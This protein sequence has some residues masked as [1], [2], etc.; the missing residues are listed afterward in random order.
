MKPLFQIGL[1]LAGLAQSAGVARGQAGPD[2]PAPAYQIQPA[3][4]LDQLLGPIA[5]YPDPLIA[6]LLPA[7]TLPAQIVLADRY[8][9]AGGDP[10]QIG[11]QP[12]DPSVQAMARYPGVLKWMDD[13]LTWTTMLG[14]AFLNQQVEVMSSIQRLRAT[15]SRLGNL[16]SSPQQEVIAEG[17]EI[18][19]IPAD[20]QVIYVPLYQ[21]GQVY[22]DPAGAV[23]FISF[24]GGL[25]L[26]GWLPYDCNWAAGGVIFWGV[27]Y[28]RPANWWHQSARQRYQG[29][30]E[31]WR[32]DHHP[33]AGAG[34]GYG[35]GNRAARGYGAGEGPRGGA[36]GAIREGPVR[37]GVRPAERPAGNARPAPVARP[38]AP[39]VARPAPGVFTGV[40]NAGATRNSSSRGQASRQAAPRPAPPAPPRAAPPARGGGGGGGGNPGPRGKR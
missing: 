14:Q 30:H 31:D 20:P 4:G 24:G 5:L 10:N 9:G 33:G 2:A 18:A 38:V 26:G 25:P 12:W 3:A 8:L 16:P 7:A 21:P 28:G 15:A 27:G 23:P 29:R 22:Y 11:A 1:L 17:G 32:P 35:P 13:N 37:P 39:P 6:S 19:I 36:P 40:N 34:A